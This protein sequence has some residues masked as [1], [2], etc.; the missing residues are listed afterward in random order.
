MKYGAYTPRRADAGIE[1]FVTERALDAGAYRRGK[2]KGPADVFVADSVPALIMQVQPEIARFQREGQKD[3]SAP[4]LAGMGEDR[5]ADKLTDGLIRRLST[6]R[7][8]WIEEP[9]WL[10]ELHPVPEDA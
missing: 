8:A 6:D 4:S 3:L 7:N 2:T 1:F 10:D 5:M 9:D